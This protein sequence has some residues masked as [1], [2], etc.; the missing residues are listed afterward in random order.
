MCN[1]DK[2]Y[3]IEGGQKRVP[4]IKHPH[5]LAITPQLSNIN[6]SVMFKVN[7]VV[8]LSTL[9]ADTKSSHAYF[10]VPSSIALPK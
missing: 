4:H 1:I 7:V 6:T 3:T 9:E 2:I 10:I 8:E 5:V